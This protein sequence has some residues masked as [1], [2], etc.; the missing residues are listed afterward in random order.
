MTWRFRKSVKLFP[1][2]RLNFSRRGIST[3]IGP[4]G[5]SI[6]LGGGGAYLN[7][8]IP[9][10]GLS[11]RTNLTGGR[12]RTERS[13]HSGAPAPE[14]SPPGPASSLPTAPEVGEI[15]S[16]ETES[17][18]SSGLRPVKET[19]IEA[20]QERTALRAEVG[21]AHRELEAVGQRLQKLQN[22]FIA[23]IFRK[24]TIASLG[25]EAEELR[26]KFDELNQQLGL[27]VVKIET[28]FDE[29]F[30]EAYGEMTRAFERLAGCSAI[31]DTTSS[32]TIA[33]SERSSAGQAIQRRPVRFGLRHVSIV[34]SETPALHLSNANGGDL[35][36][37]PGFLVVADGGDF[38]LIDY[39]DVTVAA[40][41]VGFLEEEAIPP[42]S[43]VVDK[44]WAKVNKNGSPDLRFK[45]NYQ[46]PVV[47]YGQ[48]HFQSGNGLNEVYMV[49]QAGAAA[50]FGKAFDE[51]RSVIS[52]CA[53]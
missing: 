50:D 3:T 44:T 17:L 45:D 22:S 9:G 20:Y 34:D 10:T 53:V 11:S 19:L 28:S 25:A 43:K 26:A 24:K 27:C 42:D 21:A 41:Q 29:R 51:Y 16:A 30:A 23:R 15:K 14:L 40:S 5:A 33:R 2:V 37:Y 39:R 4:R 36:L 32:V 8:G 47:A 48:L 46:I 31:W 35:F 12:R 38:A 1:G 13:H 52:A 6:N 49:S 7:V 18:T